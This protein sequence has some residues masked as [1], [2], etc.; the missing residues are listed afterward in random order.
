MSQRQILIQ[1]TAAQIIDLIHQ[2]KASVNMTAIIA[3]HDE[4]IAKST[5]R[6]ICLKDGAIRHWKVKSSSL[7]ELRELIREADEQLIDLIA[8]RQG[9]ALEVGKCKAEAGLPIKNKAIEEEVLGR[10][11]QRA[12]L[13]GISDELSRSVAELLI[14]H[15]CRVQEEDR[16][17]RS[18]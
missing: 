15:S 3:T 16:I 8:V 6:Q 1:K 5:A 7:E 13:L 2:L 11:S 14:D 17:L 10:Y 9:L 4:K 18:R 12:S